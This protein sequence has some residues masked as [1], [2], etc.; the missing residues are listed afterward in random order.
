MIEL[1][2]DSST[3]SMND[4]A[5]SRSSISPSLLGSS[6][7]DT[8]QTPIA[9][10][11]LTRG[12]AMLAMIDES[13]EEANLQLSKK[14]VKSSF[15]LSTTSSVRLSTTTT[16]MSTTT[17][18]TTSNDS[19]SQTQLQRRQLSFQFANISPI[20]ATGSSYS[21]WQTQESTV[22]NLNDIKSFSV[23]MQHTLSE[24]EESS[25]SRGPATY[26]AIQ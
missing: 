1:S 17:T 22:A 2:Q 15:S 7:L 11:A 26:L 13:S 24:E 3:R 20:S 12:M 8:H 6:Y 4:L 23:L 5:S 16:T 21:S 25:R 18:T 14:K 9:Q 10:R 19:L